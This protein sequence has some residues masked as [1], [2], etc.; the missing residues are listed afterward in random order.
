M[1]S[2]L[3]CRFEGMR[4]LKSRFNCVN[5]CVLLNDKDEMLH[6]KAKHLTLAYSNDLSSDFPSQLL[7]F[8]SIMKAELEKLTTIRQIAEL[9]IVKHSSIM[10]SVPDVATAFKIFLTIPITVAS[11][12]GS[13]SKLTVIKNYLTS[14]ISQERLSA[15]SI[16]SIEN[17]RARNESA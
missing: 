14:T 15:L 3:S 4:T 8:H 1:I 5:P 2:Q 7:S 6:D 16:L 12:G 9:L 17:E 10:T 13:F 11:A